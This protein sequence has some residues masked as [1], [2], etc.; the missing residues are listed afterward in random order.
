M[1]TTSF[2]LK[3]VSDIQKKKK[4]WTF[5]SLLYKKRLKTKIY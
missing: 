1:K 2:E 3:R 5:L 4:E